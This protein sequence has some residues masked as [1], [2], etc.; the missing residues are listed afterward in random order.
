MTEP[1]ELPPAV[2]AD[3]VALA[4]DCLDRCRRVDV[5]A[6]V[7]GDRAL[8][9][10]LEDQRRALSLLAAAAPCPSPALHARISELAAAPTGS[11]RRARLVR[12]AAAAAAIAMVLATA[13]LQ[14][15]TA[16]RT[17]RSGSGAGPADTSG[18]RTA[19]ADRRRRPPATRGF[20]RGRLGSTALV[21]A[22]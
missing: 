18:G 14:P 3:L 22:R 19:A 6:C 1:L 21:S 17:G 20:E 5:E 15:D 10:A 4:D 7:A 8:T 16:Q 11:P 12:S 13:V 2:E 9:A